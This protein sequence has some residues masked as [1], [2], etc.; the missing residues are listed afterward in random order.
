MN[1]SQ[2]EA[3]AAKSMM[4][5]FRANHFEQIGKKERSY[6]EKGAEEALEWALVLVEAGSTKVKIQDLYI[7][8]QNFMFDTGYKSGREAKEND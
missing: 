4:H 3:I 2:L 6:Y 8:M 7:Y 5:H 1:R